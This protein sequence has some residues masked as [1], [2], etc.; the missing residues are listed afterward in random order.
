MSDSDRIVPTSQVAKQQFIDVF[1]L[2]GMQIV[3]PDNI[4]VVGDSEQTGVS[5]SSRVP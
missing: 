4:E 5:R 3:V 2:I 1:Q